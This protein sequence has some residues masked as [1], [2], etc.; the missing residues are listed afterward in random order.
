MQSL[1]L[2]VMA[3]LHADR[4][5]Q[6]LGFR[7]FLPNPSIVQVLAP[8]LC[9][10]LPAICS[11]ALFLIVGKANNWNESR[12]E[13]YSSRTPA[14]TSVRNMVHFAQLF[15]SKGLQQYDW[16]CGLFSCENMNKYGQ[17]TPP[18]YNLSAFTV[19]TALYHSDQ[20]D[21]ANPAD[22]EILKAALPAGVVVQDYHV[23][24]QFNHLDYT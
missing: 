8:A 24:L 15:R 21:L 13:V 4:V 23:S 2:D 1:V 9:T 3:D 10:G 11:N 19:K 7:E 14:G 6:L 22:V 5:I 18:V 17:K 12:V 16:G 20:D